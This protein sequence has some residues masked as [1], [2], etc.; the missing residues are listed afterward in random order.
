LKRLLSC[1]REHSNHQLRVY[2]ENNEEVKPG[3]VG[4]IVLRSPSVMKGY[5]KNP[6]VTKKAIKD[7]WLHTGDMATI[8]KDQY[9][10]IVDRKHDLII[11]GGE[12][13]YP[14][15]V[16]EVLFSHPSILEAAVTGVYHPDFGEVPK[17]FVVLREGAK[18]TEEEIIQFCKKH[19]ASYKCPKSVMFLDDLPKTASGKITRAGIREK[20]VTEKKRS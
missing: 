8:D 16:E 7:G 12:N 10:Y 4:E 1:G 14:K 3:E 20:Y 9:I 13:I 17:A 15:E 18:A 2:N 5:W 19:L 6:E 11:S